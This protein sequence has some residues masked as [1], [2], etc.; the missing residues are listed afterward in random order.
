MSKHI[1]AVRG[2]N[3]ILPDESPYW[4][5]VETICRQV[6]MNYHYCEIRF[7]VVEQ[8]ALFK[9]SIGEVTDIVEKEMYTFDDRNGDS[10]TLRPEGTACCVRAAI[11]HGLLHNQ[12]QRLWYMGLMFRHER[13]QKGRYRQF[14]QLGVEAFGMSGAAVDVEMIL[15][16]RRLFDALGL[17]PHLELQVNTLATTEVRTAYRQQL[18]DYYQ[19]HFDELDADSQHRL[20]K[21][22]LRILDS[23]NPQTQE[24]NQGAPK[25][26]DCLDEVSK[27][28]FEQVCHMLDSLNITYAITPTLVRGLDYYC[29]TVFEWVTHDLG[30]QGTVCAGGRYDGLVE[31]LGGRSTPAV[32]FAM[33]LERIVLLLK[34]TQDFKQQPDVF[35]VLVGDTALTYGLQLAEQLRDQLPYLAVEVNCG[36]G[37]FKS[38]FKRADKSGAAFA[39]IIGDEEVTQQQVGFKDLRQQSEQETLAADQL[40]AQLKRKI[41]GLHSD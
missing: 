34:E 10:L 4:D 16:S 18:V 13:P 23:K 20:D 17:L 6:M 39:V 9:R 5:Y 28:H 21:N 27:Q 3:D 32:G 38:Q 33:G 14:H 29:H 1:Q 36:G 8:T 37:S 12:T 31:Q 19:A 30:A 25:L 41:N 7:P 11:Q 2:M 40:A 26:I 15:L 24:L 35:F 22:P